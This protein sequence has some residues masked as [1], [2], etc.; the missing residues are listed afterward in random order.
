MFY[1]KYCL[2]GTVKKAINTVIAVLETVEAV[3]AR[4]KQTQPRPPSPSPPLLSWE[5]ALPPVPRLP[6]RPMPSTSL[7]VPSTASPPYWGETSMSS[8]PTSCSVSPPGGVIPEDRLGGYLP[9]SHRDDE[10]ARLLWTGAIPYTSLHHLLSAI[11][12]TIDNSLHAPSSFPTPTRYSCAAEQV[13][14]TSRIPST[15]I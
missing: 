5:P 10:R 2:V 13:Q 11:V 12:T 1:H 6:S 15:Y 7:L 3:C 8:S 14:G 9:V 4:S